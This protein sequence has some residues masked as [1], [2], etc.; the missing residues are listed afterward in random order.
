MKNS[1]RSTIILREI[2]SDTPLDDVKEIFNYEGCKP[3]SSLKSEI[4][5]SWF[6]TFETEDFAKD[7]LLDLRLKKRTFRGQP[8][9]ARLKTETVV[10][11]Y[12][13]VQTAPPIP[14]V[15][16]IMGYPGMG[17]MG[18]PLP[19]NLQAYGYLPPPYVTDGI[20]MVPFGGLVPPQPLLVPVDPQLHLA[21]TAAAGALQQQP[22]VGNSSDSA[23]HAGITPPEDAKGVLINFFICVM[24]IIVVFRSP[25]GA[26]PQQGEHST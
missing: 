20:P 6:V 9:K 14:P 5:D 13:P 26:S 15:F 23:S 16:P 17:M 12:Y 7:T 24:L 2:P 8:V 11:S 19:I 22:V 25:C 1:T 3:I 18:P 21:T 10:K 4:G